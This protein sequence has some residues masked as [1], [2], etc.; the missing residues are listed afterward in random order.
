MNKAEFIAAVA[1]KTTLKRKDVEAMFNGFWDVVSE[2]LAKGESVN[3]VGIGSFATKQ[4]PARSGRNPLTG[5]TLEIA[6]K[7]VPQ[8]KAGAK[9]KDAVG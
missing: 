9:L 5:K 6:A 4:R 1:E 2:Q 3:F 8:F 7:T